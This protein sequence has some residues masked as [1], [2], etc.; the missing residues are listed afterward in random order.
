MSETEAVYE[1]EGLRMV[2][3]GRSKPANDG[4]DLRI[5]DGEIFGVL[6][7]NGAGKSTLVKQLVGLLRPTAGRIRLFG[8]DITADPAFVGLNVGYM[9]QAAFALHHLKVREAIFFSAHLR[10]ADRVTSRRQRD[11]L[12]ERWR[13][14]PVADSVVRRLSGGQRQLLQLATAM[15]GDPPVLILDEPTSDLDPQRR[16]LVWQ[17]LTEINRER[18]TTILFI[19]HDALESEK[20]VRRVAL[21]RAGNIVALGRPSDLK[22][23]LGN[24][25]RLEVALRPEAAPSLPQN[26]D[27]VRVSEERWLAYLDPKEVHEIMQQIPVDVLDDF[28]LHFSTL[29]DLYLHY[30]ERL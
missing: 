29:E 4:I 2:Y 12:I 25:L 22:Q 23:A 11:E 3:P 16:R 21:M 5:A 14:G 10:G 20:V 7:D 28:H 18:G 27:W 26:L 13:L 30:A 1:V 17:V 8:R 24:Q 19:T 15:A 6:G 9:P